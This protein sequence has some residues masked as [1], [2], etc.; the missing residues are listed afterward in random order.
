MNTKSIIVFSAVAVALALFV[1]PLLA[2]TNANAGSIS[3]SIKGTQI[4]KQ[5]SQCIAGLGFLLSC[6]NLAGNLQFN[7]GSQVAGS[8]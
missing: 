4:I 5:D 3:Q 8:K 2:A 1:S 7:T 6:N